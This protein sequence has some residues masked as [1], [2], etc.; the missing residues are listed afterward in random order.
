LIV[1]LSTLSGEPPTDIRSIYALT[2]TV[3]RVKRELYT[4]LTRSGQL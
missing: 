2:P 4:S 1:W 3:N